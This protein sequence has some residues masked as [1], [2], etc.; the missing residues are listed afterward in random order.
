VLAAA[1]TTLAEQ[2]TA[3]LA[4]LQAA[5]E[6]KMSGEVGAGGLPPEEAEAGE[7]KQ[8]GKKQRRKRGSGKHGAVASSSQGHGGGAGGAAA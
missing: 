5:D 8:G 2:Q 3:A 6:L 4:T 7:C 1:K